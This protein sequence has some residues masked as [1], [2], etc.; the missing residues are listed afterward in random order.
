MVQPDER[1][2]HQRRKGSG[3]RFTVLALVLFYVNIYVGVLFSKDDRR[4]R[5][6][7]ISVDSKYLQMF[8]KR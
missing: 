2:V 3:C 8:V 1:V 4:A 5:S 7:D 6:G